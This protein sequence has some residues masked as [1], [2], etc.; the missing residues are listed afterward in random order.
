MTALYVGDLHPEVTELMILKR[1]RPAGPIKSVHISRNRKSGYSLG[2]AYV[3]FCYKYDAER[4]LEMFDFELLLERPMRVMWSRF[5]R[6]LNWTNRSNIIIKNLDKSI[7]SVDL[8]DTFSVFGKIVSCKV[9]ESKGFG[10]VQFESQEAAASAI[11]RLNGMLLND[12]YVTIQYFKDRDERKPENNTLQKLQQPVLPPC[13]KNTVAVAPSVD[14]VQAVPAFTTAASVDT[15]QADPAIT[16]APSEDPVQAV[17]DFVTAPLEDTVPGF[18][19]APSEDSIPV[20][21]KASLVDTVPGIETAPLEDIVPIFETAPSVDSVPDFIKAP[22]IERAPAEAPAALSDT[23]KATAADV[24]SSTSVANVD[25]V[26]LDDS[27]KD[28]PTSTP[29][30]KRLTIYMLES[31]ALDDQIQK[32]YDYMLPL[33]KKIHPSLASKIT[34][35]LIQGENNFEI[36]NMISVPE[37]LRAKVH[38]MDSLLKA[39]EAGHKP[40]TLKMMYRHKTSRNRKK[41][42]N[43][44]KRNI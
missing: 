19:T 37:L 33:V 14:P 40:E 11:N 6:M 36:M 17:T 29:S 23:A 4:A 26:Q 15:V 8:F 41:K 18:E 43:K 1:F 10:Y 16:T 28:A 2:Y 25:D 34:W 30:G 13:N 27:T 42:N 38:E 21:E 7:Q 39:R 12:Q 22:A 35:M 5:E 24:E 32:A 3:N 31:A 20:F 9:V 44:N